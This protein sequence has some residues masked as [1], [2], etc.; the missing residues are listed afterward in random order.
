MPD[1]KEDIILLVED[2]VP[3]KTLLTTALQK[4]GYFVISRTHRLE[5]LQLLEFGSYNLV[6]TDIWMPGITGVEVIQAVRRYRPSTPVIAI[7]GGTQEM[8]GDQTLELAHFVGAECVLVKPFHLE[9]L[10][11][12]VA[13]ALAARGGP[14]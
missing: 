5:L 11:A 9:Q 13:G 12:A 2:D 3:M 7:S 10:L 14:A 4:E 8:T 1:S 6:V